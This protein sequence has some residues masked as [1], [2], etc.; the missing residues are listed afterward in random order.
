[1]AREND[2]T[3]EDQSS[4]GIFEDLSMAQVFA[5]ALAAA[6]AFALS[7]QIGIAGSII[8]AAIGAA[9]SAVATQVYKNILSASADKI[10]SNVSDDGGAPGSTVRMTS[11]SSAFS[12]ADETAVAPRPQPS[13]IDATTQTVMKTGTPVAPPNMRHAVRK[14]RKSKA[15]LTATIITIA[16]SLVAVIAYAVIVNLAT[17]GAGIGTKLGSSST[18]NQTTVVE[19]TKSTSAPSKSQSTSDTSSSSQTTDDSSSATSTDTGSGTG[20]STTSDSSGTRSS[21]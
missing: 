13:P 17:Q 2:E 19:E 14:R 7:T 11:G 5:S 16:I 8:G 10:R 18:D 3:N 20:S 4:K 1:M 9:A 21:W 6:T 12:G 15:I